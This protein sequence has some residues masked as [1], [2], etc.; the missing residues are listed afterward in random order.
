MLIS[1]SESYQSY[2]QPNPPI[3]SIAHVLSLEKN[4]LL[5]VIL[6]PLYLSIV[7]TTEQIL[8]THFWTYFFQLFS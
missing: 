3:F 6:L 4:Q 5:Q 2:I 1:S 8:Y 7:T